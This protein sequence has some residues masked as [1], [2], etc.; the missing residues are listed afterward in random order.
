[1]GVHA[2]EFYAITHESVDCFRVGFVGSKVEACLRWGEGE[3]QN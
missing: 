1:M 3:S 2:G